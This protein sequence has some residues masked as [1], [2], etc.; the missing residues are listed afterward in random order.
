MRDRSVA[1]HHLPALPAAQ[2]HDN[3][4]G[5]ASIERPG[6]AVVPQIVEVEVAETDRA[7][8]LRRLGPL[9]SRCRP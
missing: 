4:S 6:R 3:V 1:T 5:E 2:S 7:S 9:S 8:G